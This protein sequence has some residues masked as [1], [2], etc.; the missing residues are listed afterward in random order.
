[1]EI[2]NYSIPESGVTD[3]GEK[4]VNYIISII[5]RDE[6]DKMWEDLRF[7]KEIVLLANTELS[8]KLD[9]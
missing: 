9:F 6:F 4:L 3:K 5:G 1:M 7:A 8:H 2:P